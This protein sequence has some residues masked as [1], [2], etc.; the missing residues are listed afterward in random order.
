[1]KP[2]KIIDEDSRFKG[3]V[4]H[5]H[6]ATGSSQKNWNT[7]VN[8]SAAKPKKS[9]NWSKILIVTLLALA[10]LGIVVGLAIELQ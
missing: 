9:R 6:R 4:R 3:S 5:Y 1:M 10:V 7:W 8:G 2:R